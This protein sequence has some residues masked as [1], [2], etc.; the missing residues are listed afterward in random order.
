M[1]SMI[2]VL[3]HV[4]DEGIYFLHLTVFFYGMIKVDVYIGL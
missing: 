4:D 3:L 1:T 2:F